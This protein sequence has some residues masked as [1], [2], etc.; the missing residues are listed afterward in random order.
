MSDSARCGVLE[1]QIGRTGYWAV[2]FA[3]KSLN[4]HVA[5]IKVLPYDA[6]SFE[7]SQAPLGAA[8]KLAISE[9]SKRGLSVAASTNAC[10]DVSNHF[11][12]R[13]IGARVCLASD[14]SRRGVL[15]S[16]VKSYWAVRLAD[17]SRNIRVAD[18]KL[19]PSD[20]ASFEPSQAPLS[21]QEKRANESSNQFLSIA[22]STNDC[23]ECPITLMA[24][25][26]GP[27]FAS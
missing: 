9:S 27:A 15:E 8:E 16:R 21:A 4:I 11:D 23:A 22:A 18:L 6:A 14:S 19:L 25:T 7:L 26:L 13:H 20:A 3:D 5:D 10:I 24:G 1:S 17:K 12:G 2:Q